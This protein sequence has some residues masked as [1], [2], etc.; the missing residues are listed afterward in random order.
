MGLQRDRLTTSELPRSFYMNGKLKAPNSK[1]AGLGSSGNVKCD[2][3]SVVIEKGPLPNFKRRSGMARQ[4]GAK[5][6]LE[7]GRPTRVRPVRTV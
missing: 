4:P 6:R 3:R 5:S 2:F 1:K 7:R